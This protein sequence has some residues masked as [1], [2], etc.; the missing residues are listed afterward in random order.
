MLCFA[1]SLNE[2]NEDGKGR[3]DEGNGD[4]DDSAD[5]ERQ[6]DADWHERDMPV[7]QF[8]ADHLNRVA[9]LQHAFED[10]NRDYHVE[11][12]QELFLDKD[13]PPLSRRQPI[14]MPDPSDGYQQG[15][16]ETQLFCDAQM[17]GLEHSGQQ[18]TARQ[19]Q[20]D[21]DENWQQFFDK[22]Q[23]RRS[24]RVAGIVRFV[25]TPVQGLQWP[26]SRKQCDAGQRKEKS[27]KDPEIQV[28]QSGGEQHSGVERPPIFPDVAKPVVYKTQ[29]RGSQFQF[30][31]QRFHH[32][33][34]KNRPSRHGQQPD[35]GW[36]NNHV[37]SR[38]CYQTLVAFQ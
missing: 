9:V 22:R 8:L 34:G 3:A 17:V 20:T 19:T 30:I 15:K 33:S 12:A 27:D 14:F 36:K 4:A 31:P 24:L 28:G 1:Q 7:E 29:L 11:H 10:K 26:V 23:K 32:G 2:G 6:D 38:A 37:D 16:N 35:Q 18:R 13:L 25:D 21:D 5:D